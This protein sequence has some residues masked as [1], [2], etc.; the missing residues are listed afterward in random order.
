MMAINLLLK[1]TLTLLLVTSLF[2]CNQQPLYKYIGIVTKVHDGDS[3]HIT[4]SGQ[5]R[6]IIRLA[7]IDAPE[8]KQ[9][10][11]IAS[12]DKLR[13]MI[14]NQPAEARCHKT[15][16]Y[17]RHVCVVYFN[18]QDINL[19]MTKSGM[20]WHYKD[21]QNE[22]S[23]FQRWAYALAESTARAGDRG[24]WSGDSVAPWVYRKQN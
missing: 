6:V 5:K 9:S 16:R 18:G 10:F 13:S 24:L 4:P 3:I 14:L 2:G 21:Y 12:R 22:Q 15:D 23:Q 11:G 20:A 8:L 19:Q 1:T 17:K 7:G